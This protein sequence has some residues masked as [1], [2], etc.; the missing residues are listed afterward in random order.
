ME[1]TNKKEAIAKTKSKYDISNL[2]TKLI[3]SKYV[4]FSLNVSAFKHF[5]IENGEIEVMFSYFI[6]GLKVKRGFYFC[7]D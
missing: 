6:K 7:L 2:K 3:E 5:L 1:N 4:S